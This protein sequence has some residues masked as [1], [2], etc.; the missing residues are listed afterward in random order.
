M[1]A[2]VNICDGCKGSGF[3]P[4]HFT[5]VP[6]Q[7]CRCCM[8]AGVLCPDGTPSER[9]RHGATRWYNSSAA[10][11]LRTW[12]AAQVPKPVQ[13]NP[14]AVDGLRAG[15]SI[16]IYIGEFFVRN[17]IVASAGD[18]R[19]IVACDFDKI[20]FDTKTGESISKY[21]QER[22]VIPKRGAK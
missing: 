18:R 15:D 7:T 22:I 2:G 9:Y 12:I 11:G 10:T 16:K 17:G 19:V 1:V 8:G 6:V 5:N 13:C 14:N 20:P 4:R 21:R 3:D